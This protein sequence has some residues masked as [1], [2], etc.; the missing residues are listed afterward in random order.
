MFRHQQLSRLVRC[1]SVALAVLSVVFLP[2]NVPATRGA[3]IADAVADRI[4]ETAE[5]DGVL[6]VHVGCG[7]GKR[8]VALG[9]DDGRLVLGLTR[10]AGQVEVARRR[11]AGAGLGGRVAIHSWSGG[12]L[13]LVDN[14]ARLIV[15]EEPATVSRDESLRVLCPGGVAIHGHDEQWE[16]TVKP[17]PEEI[18]QWT[19]YLRDASG[20]AV[21][22]DTRVG[23]PRHMQWVCG[24]RWMRNHHMLASISAIVSEGGRIFYILD[25][26][27]SA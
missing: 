17:W 2:L 11:I 8:S 20:N 27:P 12:R 21:A 23:P 26:G 19:H 3:A 6:V 9:A 1:S 10:N 16:K 13:P 14:V 18:D 22:R 25:E 24:P 5:F 4:L 15:V 7:D